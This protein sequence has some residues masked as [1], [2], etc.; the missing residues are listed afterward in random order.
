M[1]SESLS[2]N[3]GLPCGR[4]IPAFLAL[5]L[6]LAHA[7][8]LP[9]F[10]QTLDEMKDAM[11]MMVGSAAICSGYLKRPEVL[12]DTRQLAREQL[13]KVG[14]SS[15]EADAFSDGIATAALADSSTEMQQQVA[16]EIINIPAI[17]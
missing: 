5:L 7:G 9:A 14:M 15:S 12:E 8:P 16:C 3:S 17:K 10:A 13:A 4:N 11:E 2:N 1:D 6:V